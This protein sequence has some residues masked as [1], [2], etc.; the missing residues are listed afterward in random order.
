LGLVDFDIEIDF[1][2][3]AEPAALADFP[4]ELGKDFVG[5]L[6]VSKALADFP[7]DLDAALGTKAEPAALGA[8]CLG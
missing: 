1:D 3:T 4:E 2:P 8:R 5:T 6:A 7:D